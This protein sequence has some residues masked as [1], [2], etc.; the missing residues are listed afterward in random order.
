MFHVHVPMLHAQR[1][2]SR[3]NISHAYPHLNTQLIA[4]LNTTAQGLQATCA[5]VCPQSLKPCALNKRACCGGTNGFREEC[6][7]SSQKGHIEKCTHS[8]FQASL[9]LLALCVVAPVLPKL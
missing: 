9:L 8:P 3:P 1:L 5:K 6:V 7:C 4:Y 2:L